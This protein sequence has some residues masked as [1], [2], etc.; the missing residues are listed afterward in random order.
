MS[1]KPKLTG[2]DWLKVFEIRCKSK[3]G[4]PLN[5]VERKLVDAAYESDKKRYSALDKDVFNATV[6]AGSTRRWK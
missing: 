1:D 3:R 2:G 5:I 6:P 4:I